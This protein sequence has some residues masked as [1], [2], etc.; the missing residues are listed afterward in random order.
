MDILRVS[1]KS[2]PNAV[3]GA[4]ANM[5]REKH[6]VRMQV[7]GAASLNQAIKA[8]AI[9]RGYVAPSG[10]SL[11]CVPSFLDVEIDDEKRTAIRLD[12]Y[13]NK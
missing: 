3:A 6:Q 2:N 7:I 11:Y 8:I 13:E 12:I 10:K 1:A 5:M 9:A 4:I